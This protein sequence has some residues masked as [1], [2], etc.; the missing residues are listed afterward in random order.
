MKTKIRFFEV[1]PRDGLQNEEA[2]VDTSSRVE[3][4]QRLVKAGVKDV[5]IGSFVHPKWVPQMAGTDEV[6]KRLTRVPGVRYWGLVPNLRGLQRAVDCQVEHV[7]LFMSATEAHNQ[8]NLNRSLSESLEALEETAKAAQSEGMTIR[9]YI[10]TAFGCPFEGK[11]DFDVV[12]SIGEKL[13]EL[14]AEHLSL[15]DTI[16][17]GSPQ[18][19][20]RGCRRAVESFGVEKVAL[21]LHDTQG[22]ALPNAL[23][24][25]QQGVRLFDGAI[26][27]M[28]G[29][30]YAPGAAGN[31]ASEDLLNMLGQMG[32]E[33]GVDPGDLCE[34]VE[35]LGRSLSFRVRGRYFDY[36]RAKLRE[37]GAE[38]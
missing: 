18:E 37:Q 33:S 4:I 35:W 31:V 28:G 36:W 6:A 5:E 24:A 11:V 10:S 17:A 7:A 16:G 12:L 38:A 27:G 21:H 2:I 13:L 20:A 25:Y 26:G 15:G 19:V 1:G 8:S 3:M 29:C 34:V 23:M 14:G 9:A 30:P 22:L 32:G